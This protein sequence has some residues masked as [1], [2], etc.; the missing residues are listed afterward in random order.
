M[1]VSR[2]YRENLKN[3]N[4]IDGIKAIS[5][6]IIYILI[7]FVQGFTYT[8]SLSLDI[9]NTLQIIFPIFILIIGIVFI[10]LSKDKL[11]TVGLTKTKLLQ[12]LI[13]GMILAVILIIGMAVYYRVVENVSVGIIYPTLGAFGIFVIAAT[14]EEII[15]RGYIQTRLTGIINEPIIC[16]FC[17]ALLFLVMHYP[18]RWVV[19]GFSFNSLSLYYVIN[20]I[21]LHFVCDFVYKKTNCLWGAIILH[22]LYNIGQSMLVL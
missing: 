19:G 3:F 13:I 7:L 20:L 22:F 6:Y 21:V 5:L 12:S 11:Y 4:T 17:T 18:T 9:L 14:Q 2:E 8:T 10:V 1:L 15:F 16:S